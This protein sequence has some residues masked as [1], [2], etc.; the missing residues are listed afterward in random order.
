MFVHKRITLIIASILLLL[1]A[2]CQATPEQ[3]QVEV[4]RVVEIDGEEVVVTRVVQEEVV[5]TP[6][7][8]AGEETSI[9]VV[10]GADV[11]CL[12]P[13]VERLSHNLNISRH[14]YD[15]LAWLDREF[16][17]Q[18]RVAVS[19][20]AVDETTW[21]VALREGL[22][23][24][25]GEEVTAQDVLASFEYHKESPAASDI[26]TWESIEVVDDHTI[27]VTTTFPDPAFASRLTRVF[28][29]PA[30]VLE[31]DPDSLCAN[32]IG[33]GPYRLVNWTRGQSLVLE[34]VDDH[35]LSPQI[36]EVIFR[37]AP[38]ASTRI[39]M[40][41]TGEA[42]LIINVPPESVPLIEA[43]ANARVVSV[44]GIR[45]IVNIIDTRNAPLDDVLVRQAI[46][47]AV[48]MET[49]IN[50]ILGGRAQEAI[51]VH[52]PLSPAANPDLTPYEYDP[53]RARQLLEEAG[54]GDGFEMDYHYPTGRWLKDA[55][56]AQ[57]IAGYLEDVGITVN[58]RTAEYQTFFNDWSTGNY[59][60]MTMIGVIDFDGDPNSANRLFLYGEGPWSFS[61]NSPEHDELME[62]SDREMDPEA[63]MELFQ[64][65]EAIVHEQAVWCCG[66]DQYEM[67]G[68][69][70]GLNY[71]PHPVERIILWDA[72]WN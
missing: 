11:Q 49:N 27:R 22:L 63:R 29:F 16:N 64:Q 51:A 3:V 69:A 21:E 24:S 48:D 54:V 8:E 39:N 35:Y 10:Q 50:N 52:P 1:I 68:I 42:D 18:P 45:R 30:S 25:N 53:E 5:V 66:Y 61:W 47:Y 36:D 15:Q 7:A 26:S 6:T 72:T 40:L 19:W 33:S 17:Y 62:Q 9:T 23:F 28:V 41:V 70:N 46:N 14:I 37:S 2:A 32:P 43:S 12:N 4:T 71:L 38:E 65:M 20:E 58:L 13:L 55:E 57:A 59:S 34:A 44:P 31:S 60:G 56:V 67:F